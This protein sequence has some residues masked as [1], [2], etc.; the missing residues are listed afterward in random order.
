MCS[1]VFSVALGNINSSRTP[2]FDVYAVNETVEL[3]CTAI[4]GRI[5]Y[6]VRATSFLP[7]LATKYSFLLNAKWIHPMLCVYNLST[8]QMLTG[9]VALDV[10]ILRWQLHGLAAVHSH[11]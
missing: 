4:I 8:K 5:D 10:G 11:T 2:N 7:S 6:L 3:Q 1:F 9:S